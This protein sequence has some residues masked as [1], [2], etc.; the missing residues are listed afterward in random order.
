MTVRVLQVFGRMLRGGAELRTLD[1]MRHLSPS[2]YRL[3]FL[4]LSGLPGTLDGEIEALGGRVHLCP[5]GPRFPWAFSGLL[6]AHQFDVVHSHVHYFSG[7]LLRLAARAGV[8]TRIAHFRSTSDD[9]QT[10][11]RRRLQRAIMRHWIDR[12]ATHIVAVGEGA[13]ASAW[14][15][16]WQSDPRCSIVF[17]GLD[18]AAFRRQP[19]R[20]RVREEFGFPADSQMWIHV[21]RIDWSKNHLRLLRVFATWTRRG[22]AGRLLV[23]GRGQEGPVR[24]VRSEIAT[25]GL[26]EN[27]VLAGE[28]PDVARLLQAA[29]IMVYPSVREGLP[30]AVLEACAAGLPVLGS[31]IAGIQEI[32]RH[33]SAVRCLPLEAGD[34]EWAE[35]ADELLVAGRLRSVDAWKTAVSRFEASAFSVSRCA[36]QLCGIWDG[37]SGSTG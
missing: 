17:N 13:M 15:V 14:G 30:G 1:V 6:R 25:Q 36:E 22:I 21:G 35:A 27:V 16:R 37:V 23:V 9:H 32:S 7:Y 28:R 8:P 3:E 20:A 2:V 33:F 31:S 24:R 12:Y 26:G 5:L 34:E 29:D 10:N 18:V 4:S 11:L 19:E